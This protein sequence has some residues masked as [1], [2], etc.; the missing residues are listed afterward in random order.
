MLNNQF[1]DRV[2][3]IAAHSDDPMYCED[4]SFIQALNTAFP[5]CFIN[6]GPEADPYWGGSGANKPFGIADDVEYLLG[7]PVIGSIEASAIWKD[8]A[9]TKIRV[10]T[11]TTFGIDINQGASSPYLIGYI[12]VADGLKGEGS[13]WAQNN[14]YSGMG[15]GDSN[16]RGIENLPSPIYGM[17]YNHVGIGTWGAEKGIANSVAMPIRKNQAQE[18]SYTCDIANNTLVQD[19][20]K[21]S[22][23]A[24][25]L[26]RE[27]GVIING[28]KCSIADFDPSGI[29][30]LNA[31]EQFSYDYYD[32]QGRKVAASQKGLLIKQSRNTDGTVTN[33]KVMHK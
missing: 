21:L 26:D 32:L 19:K 20:S 13:E 28:A 25:L 11:Q 4:Y 27:T 10:K 22:I 3:T 12:L 23:V 5:N 2:I 29:S 9:Q 6:R 24:L 33:V 7:E 16:L 15:T 18:F 1:G 30:T 17:E 8:M 31:D 14:I